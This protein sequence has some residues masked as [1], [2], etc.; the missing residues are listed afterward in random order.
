MRKGLS[1]STVPMTSRDSRVMAA[2]ISTRWVEY[3]SVSP[4]L[5]GQGLIYTRSTGD[6]DQ[7][8]AKTPEFVTSCVLVI[9]VY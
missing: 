2:I 9:D 6:V 3:T 4:L 8:H 5:P 7:A 1:T